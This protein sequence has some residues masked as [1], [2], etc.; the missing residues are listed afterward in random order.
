MVERGEVDVGMVD[1]GG[2]VDAG[3]ADE[4]K[5]DTVCMCVC[6][7]GGDQVIYI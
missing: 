4:G 1:D 3:P 7:G 5:V 6:W 2:M